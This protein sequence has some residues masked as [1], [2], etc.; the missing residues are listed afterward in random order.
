[1]QI[2]PMPRSYMGVILWLLTGTILFAQ[3]SRPEITGQNPDPVVIMEDELFEMDTS[4]LIVSDADND[5]LTLIVEDGENYTV[6]GAQITPASDYSGSLSVPVMVYDGTEYSDTYSFRIEVTPVNDPPVITGQS[7]PLEVE[8]NNSI[9]LFT[10]ALTIEDVDPSEYTLIVLEGS[11]YTF[12]G[13]QV[14]PQTDFS[15]TLIVNVQVQED[16]VN[17]NVFGLQVEVIPVNDVPQITGQTSSITIQEEE[18]FSITLE[19]LTVSDNDNTYPDDFSLVVGAGTNY[20]ANGNTVTPSPDFNGL[21]MVPVSV[22]DGVN[23][24]EPYNFQIQVAPVNDPPIITGQATLLSVNEDSGIGLQV[25][26]LNID[27]VDNV[28]PGDFSITVY[29]GDNYTIFNGIVTPVLN[30]NG[31]LSVPVTVSDGQSSSDP[32]T[33]QIEVIPVNDPPVIVSQQAISIRQAES[34]TLSLSYLLVEDI[35]N[36]YPS[37]FTLIVHGGSNYTVSDL[38][39]TPSPEFTG[40]LTV[41]VQVN[42]GTSNS[43]L[44]NFQ[45]QVA[46]NNTPPV[47]TGQVPL[48]IAEDESLTIE[49]SHLIV[50]DPDDEYPSGFSIIILPGANY[51]VTGRKIIPAPDFTGILHVNVQVNDGLANSSPFTLQITVM[52]END[53]PDLN[54]V[55]NQVVQEDSDVH[56]VVLTGISAGRSETQKL[57]VTAKA[58]NQALFEVFELIYQSPQSSGVLRLK[59]KPDVSGAT[60]ITIT[61][62]DEPGASKSRSFLF[63]ITEVN[64]PPV[65][66]STPVKVASAGNLY[67]YIIA[68]QDVDA[69]DRITVTATQKPSWLS[70]IQRDG[71]LALRGVPPEGAGGSYSIVL[72]AKDNKGGNTKQ[73]FVLVVNSRPVVSDFSIEINEDEVFTFTNQFTLAFSDNEGQSIEK[74]VL[75]SFPRHGSLQFNGQPFNAEAE[76]PAAQISALRYVPDENFAGMDTLQWNASDGISLAA[77]PAWIFVTVF[78]GNDPPE[79][80]SL[81]SA[82]LNYFVENGPVVVASEFEAV[83]ADS[84]R[85]VSAEIGFRRQNFVS[86]QDILTYEPTPNIQGSFDA[87]A[88]ILFLSGNAAV[89]EYNQVIRS[90]RYENISDTYREGELLKSVFFTLNDGQSFSQTRDKKIKVIDKFIDLEIPS[91]F[92]PDNRQPNDTW[93][94]KNIQLY[95]TVEVNVYDARGNLVFSSNGYEKE[96]DGMFNGRPLP[97]DTYYYTIDLHL[98]FRKKSYRGSVTI[99]R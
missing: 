13:T 67:E 55:S 56:P 12:S 94:I 21:L 16:E 18:S 74:I 51:T 43:N 83:D 98:E 66:T 73:E 45:V 17:S 69:S 80:V 87:S 81:D 24:S 58:D 30:F 65:F 47:I 15:G 6:A 36:T 44:F 86:T 62:T 1:M 14:T 79:I 20:T 7:M 11:G 4:Y 5:E 39:I 23:A 25:R 29:P 31:T 28:Y 85:I 33:V 63:T 60:T 52:D 8:E 22:F 42:D 96:W 57:T 50:D 10:D 35:D 78:P 88:G 72:E 26:H 64:D 40:T 90:I 77:K 19:H 34:L 93:R 9:I 61:V 99:L 97:V 54:P 91:G 37:G 27:D 41:P 76:V 71:I 53:P 32:F 82:V 48:S 84:D 3:N 49:L 59:P 2:F 38:T 89:E 92:T 68:V 75:V 95:P 70:I 46:T